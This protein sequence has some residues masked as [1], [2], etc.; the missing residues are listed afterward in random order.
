MGYESGNST[1]FHHKNLRYDVF[2]QVDGLLLDSIFGVAELNKSE[3][4]NQRPNRFIESIE[5]G[6]GHGA[7]VGVRDDW[8]EGREHVLYIVS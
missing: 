1:K 6:F 8:T 2:T 3:A 5:D 4:R 7:V